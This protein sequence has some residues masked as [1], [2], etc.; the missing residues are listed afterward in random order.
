MNAFIFP[1]DLYMHPKDYECFAFSIPSINFKEPAHRYHWVVLP[2][3]MANSP[4]MCQVYVATALQHLKK[5]YSQMYII[6]Y[7]DDSLLTARE[8]KVLL[9]AYDDLQ[10]D[11][12]QAGLIIAPENVQKR[13]S[14]SIFRP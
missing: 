4:T 6:H 5:R 3:G 10:Y 2:Q 13:I 9:V 11:L 1:I 7:M 8:E 12:R 14:I